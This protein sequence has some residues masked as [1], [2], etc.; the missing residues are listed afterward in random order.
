[1]NSLNST[2]VD[3]PAVA[4]ACSVIYVSESLCECSELLLYFSV[5]AFCLDSLQTNFLGSCLF[6]E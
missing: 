6:P 2:A 1:M 3:Q 5:L 4:S